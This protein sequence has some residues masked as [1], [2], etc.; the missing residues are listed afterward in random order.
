LITTLLEH[1]LANAPRCFGTTHQLREMKN[2][3]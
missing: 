2:E 1:T 3:K